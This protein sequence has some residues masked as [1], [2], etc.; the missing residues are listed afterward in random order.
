MAATKAR[1][2]VV[3]RTYSAG[4]HFGEL[5]EQNGKEVILA[6]ARRLWSWQGANTLH[7]VATSGVGK[8]SRVSVE[9]D[10]I[11]LTEAVETI[12][13]SAEGAENLRKA[14]WK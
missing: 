2:Y 10:K 1:P 6:R 7:E 8:G 13:C 12:S 4:V 5:V 14:K 3:I 11:V 9:V